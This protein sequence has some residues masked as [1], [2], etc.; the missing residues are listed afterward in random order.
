MVTSTE[1]IK[2][3]LFHYHCDHCDYNQYGDHCPV[4]CLVAT[5]I[6][7]AEKREFSLKY[8]KALETQEPD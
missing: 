8:Y 1:H 7:A 4:T 6:E 5:A 2:E 3:V